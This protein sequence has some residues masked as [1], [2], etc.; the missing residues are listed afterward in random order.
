MPLLHGVGDQND[1]YLLLDGSGINSQFK[2]CEVEVHWVPVVSVNAKV[3]P[4]FQMFIA[5][6]VFGDQDRGFWKNLE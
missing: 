3:R 2:V 1:D 6:M 4:L 5:L